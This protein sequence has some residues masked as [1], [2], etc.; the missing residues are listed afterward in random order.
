MGNKQCKQNEI[1][2]DFVKKFVECGE[3]YLD[4]PCGPL[5][6]LQ[7]LHQVF[8]DAKDA[9]NNN[10]APLSAHFDPDTVDEITVVGADGVDEAIN[11]M[12]SVANNM[13]EE[14]IGF[15]TFPVAP[16]ATNADSSALALITTFLVTSQGNYESAAASINRTNLPQLYGNY[17]QLGLENQ[18]QTALD[19]NEVM[20]MILFPSTV[21]ALDSDEF[22]FVSTFEEDN[23]LMRGTL[24]NIMNGCPVSA[25][26]CGPIIIPPGLY[27]KPQERKKCKS[28]HMC[29]VQ[30][31]SWNNS[32]GGMWQP[33]GHGGAVWQGGGNSGGGCGCGHNREHDHDRDRGIQSSSDN[34][35]CK[36]ENLQ[37]L[38]EPVVVGPKSDPYL[39]PFSLAGFNLF[40]GNRDS[41]N[42]REEF[43]KRFR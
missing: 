36:Y 19:I 29:K 27:V 35:S 25:D 39:I 37:N 18:I 10:Q 16:A 23:K 8:V 2:P 40:S 20:K 6:C 42:P 21:A 11:A 38:C 26:E 41:K 33:S 4:D 15:F 43:V 5:S 24:F 13:N 17:S 32:V 7:P 12:I 14:G 31:G 9:I 22:L 3:S 28:K 30:Q 1:T 34:C